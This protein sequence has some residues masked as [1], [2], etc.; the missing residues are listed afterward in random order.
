M[1]VSLLH[2]L[3]FHDLT[4]LQLVIVEDDLLTTINHDLIIGVAEL[5]LFKL[6]DILIV[7]NNA[8]VVLSDDLALVELLLFVVSRLLLLVLLDLTHELDGLPGMVCK[9]ATV[10]GLDVILLLGYLV[11]SGL[12]NKYLC[13]LV[14]L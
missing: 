4:P 5:I 8:L 2:R 12:L 10:L 3:I 6:L 7:P 11:V 1:E 14:L 9:A 13:R